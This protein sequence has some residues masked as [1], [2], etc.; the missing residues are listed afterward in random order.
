[1][2]KEN[3]PRK[4]SIRSPS[5]AAIAKEIP[6]Y[7]HSLLVVATYMICVKELSHFSLFE[8]GFIATKF[9]WQDKVLLEKPLSIT[10]ELV[11]ENIRT[12]G[13]V[14][15]VP[16]KGQNTDCLYRYSIGMKMHIMVIVDSIGKVSDLLPSNVYN[17]G[18]ALCFQ[19]MQWSIE[20]IRSKAIPRFYSL[21]E[22][23]NF[24]NRMALEVEQCDCG[25]K[26]H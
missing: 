10:R 5:A 6:A 13:Y 9:L 7:Y 25:C 14:I 22:K 24:W 1:M 12:I 16:S 15:H 21:T 26:K 8:T 18:G 17:C 20:P 19:A 2:K 23:D 3:A 11:L 4:V